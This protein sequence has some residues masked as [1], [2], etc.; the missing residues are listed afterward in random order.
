MWYLSFAVLVLK[1][2]Y[3]FLEFLVK[4]KKIFILLVLI[5]KLHIMIT[6]L[7]K[8]L[9]YKI[10]FNCFKNLMLMYYTKKIIPLE[11]FKKAQQK[12]YNFLLNRQ[13]NWYDPF[14]ILD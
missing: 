11:F 6:A 2:I 10:S 8:K 3:I 7:Q 14:I 12:T 13:T 9:Q 1:N 4:Q 5:P